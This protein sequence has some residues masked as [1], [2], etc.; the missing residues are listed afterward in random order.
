MAQPVNSARCFLLLNKFVIKMS[1]DDYLVIS[2]FLLLPHPELANVS[3]KHQ[4]VGQLRHV[5]LVSD[6]PLSLVIVVPAKLNCLLLLHIKF[7]LLVVFLK[8]FTN[9]E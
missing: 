1:I 9:V 7:Y 4:L 8:E 2:Y 5:K 3:L 6:A